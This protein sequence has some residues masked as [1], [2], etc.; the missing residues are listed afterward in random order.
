MGYAV[1][2]CSSYGYLRG[3]G[4]GIAYG[5]MH[6]LSMCGTDTRMVLPGVMIFE[7]PKP[8]D[9]S[10]PGQS[11]MRLLMFEYPFQY[12]SAHTCVLTLLVAMAS[13]PPKPATP[14]PVQSPPKESSSLGEFVEGGDKPKSPAAFGRRAKSGTRISSRIVPLYCP[15][16]CPRADARAGVRRRRRGGRGCDAHG[17]EGGHEAPAAAP[18]MPLPYAPM[19]SSYGLARYSALYAPNV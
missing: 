6:A 7:A 4:V 10:K 2:T 5:A 17:H 11:T 3:T 13:S 14:P 18:C 1:L 16:L 19:P 9:K 8:K 12:W 15:A